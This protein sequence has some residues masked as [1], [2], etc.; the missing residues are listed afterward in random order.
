M[1]RRH[2]VRFRHATLFVAIAVLALLPGCSSQYLAPFTLPPI[3]PQ[4][5]SILF[6]TTPPGSLA[7]NASVT[8]SAA[9]TD[10]SSTAVINWTLTCGS[11]GA[12]GSISPTQ[13]SSGGSITYVAPAAIPTGNTV[14]ITATLASDTTKTVSASITITPPQPITVAFVGV[15][16]AFLQVSSIVQI[17]AKVTNDTSANP[18]V[19]WTVTCGS[20][21][22]GT[23]NP[24]T[25]SSEGPTDYTAPTAVPT[26]NVVTITAT[27]VTDSTKSVSANVT[28]T[29]TAA[30]LANGTYVFHLSGPVGPAANALAGVIVAQDGRITGGEQDFSSYAVDQTAQQSLTFYDQNL[31]GTYTTTPDGNL[32]ITINTNDANVG[33]SGTETLNG[34]IVSPSRALL[35][36]LNGVVGTGTLDLQSLPTPLVAP[37]GGYAFTTTGVDASGSPATIGG[38][39]N[40]DD[41]GMTSGTISGNGSVID[42]NDDLVFNDNL[43]PGG[44]ALGA[45]TVSTPD[46]FGRVKFQLAPGAGAKFVSLLFVG[47]LV[48]SVYI[49]LVESSPDDF[50][51]VMGGTALSQGTSTGTFS[52]SSISGLTYVFGAEG[53][54]SAGPLQVAGVFTANGG[55]TVSGTLN[56]NDLT[57]K[58]TQNPL[59]FTGSYAVDATGRATLSNLTDGVTFTYQIVF[60]LTGTGTT[61]GEGL[62]L[63]AGDGQTFGGRALPQTGTFSAATFSGT[64]AMSALPSGAL[65]PITSVAGASTDSLTGF[66]DFAS[67]AT[68][69]PVSGTLA[70]AS[71]GIF[72]GT[73]TGL[74]A[75]SNTTTDNF[76]FYLAD[77]TEGVMI[78]TDNTQLTLGYLQLQQP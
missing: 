42:V 15:P 8:L 77:G 18:Q 11:A 36:E 41:L 46:S 54:D 19:K 12:C 64:Y 16:P 39:I 21:A 33:N 53:E 22:C 2:T 17:A 35:T 66:A 60:Y 65:G 13:T 10:N 52:A 45:S 37:S 23:F 47:Y 59:A 56:W 20:S 4:P 27:S 69:Y 73:L 67:G 26:G 50:L 14:T 1:G 75:S 78:E 6:V 49:R 61:N 3:G 30:T 57:D 25:T 38:V 44:Q 43:F 5:N 51:G 40:V 9:V 68:D 71:T 74:D 7:I 24:I 28:I 32:Q 48:D 29:G 58:T 34:V 31:T 62:V 55:G 70:A 63:S 72:T 76:T